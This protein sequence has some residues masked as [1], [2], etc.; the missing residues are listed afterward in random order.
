MT[1]LIFLG[2]PGSGKGTQARKLGELLSVPH[3]AV[4]DILREAIRAKTDIGKLAE[5][6]MVQGKLVPNELTIDI[7]KERL[8]ESDCKKG[9]IIDGFPRNLDQAESLEKI[10]S[11]M[12]IKS[13][14]AVYFSIPLEDVVKRLSERRSCKRCG[15]VYHLSFHPPKKE[16]FCDRCGGEL[17]QR[18]DDEE[19]IIKTRFAVYLD[20]TKPLVSHFEEQE[21][22][23]KIDG[24]G[25]VEEV[26]A[27][28]CKV[29]GT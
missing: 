9:F 15:A 5:K 20:Q 22:L 17:Y 10:F 21:R 1:V 2:P 29:T 26:F 19:D 27:E 24:R 23:I 18:H 14:K 16:G 3:I 25:S 13:Y 12:G 6:F 4:G 11:E 8:R 7:M 28:L